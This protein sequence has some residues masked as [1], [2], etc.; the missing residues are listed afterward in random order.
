MSFSI[1]RSCLKK[2]NESRKISGWSVSKH[3]LSKIWK[4]K[5]KLLDLFLLKCDEDYT[6]GLLM[7]RHSTSSYNKVRS[8]D[9]VSGTI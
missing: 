5:N 4:I 9:A 7:N 1:G 3:V 2:N 8:S 6:S